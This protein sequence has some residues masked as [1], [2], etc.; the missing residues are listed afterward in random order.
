MTKEFLG[1]PVEGDDIYKP[2]Y[3]TVE[4]WPVEVF[5]NAVEKVLSHPIVLGLY[6]DQY[7]PYYNDG[8]SCTF[9]VG[10]VH[11]LFEGAQAAEEDYFLYSW[12]EDEA[13]EGRFWCSEWTHRDKFHRIVGDL[14]K[15]Y[16]GTGYPRQFKYNIDPKDQPNPQL[17]L[18]V[19]A[20]IDAVSKGH[21]D[22]SLMGLFGDHVTVRIDRAAGKV[23]LESYEHD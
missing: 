6:W 11:F 1:M 21:Y 23:V 16:I 10:E 19:T 9:R 13:E 2:S 4:Q 22:N 17:F 15:E 14:T 3:G 18:D 7:T 12:Q 5:Q 20:L 8:E